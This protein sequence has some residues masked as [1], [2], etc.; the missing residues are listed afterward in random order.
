MKSDEL[1]TALLNATETAYSKLQIISEEESCKKDKP[2]KWSYKEVVGHLIDS[3][4]NNHQRFVRA[5]FKNDLVFIGYQQDDWVNAQH[6]QDAPWHSLLR[7]WY[8]FNLHLTRII[9]AVPDETLLLKR[10]L[11]NLDEIAWK[12]VAK[13]EPVTLVYFINDYIEHMQHHL[14]QIISERR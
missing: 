9:A 3:A 4:S 5:Q 14:K 6:Y 11:H 2:E 12:P 13:S 8:E 1:S 7:L 10:T